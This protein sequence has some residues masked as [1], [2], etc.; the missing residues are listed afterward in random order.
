MPISSEGLG[1]PFGM[2]LY[3]ADA[4]LPAGA[5]SSSLEALY[6]EAAPI[7]V[8]SGVGNPAW[9]CGV[10]RSVIV[11]SQPQL[12]PAHHFPHIG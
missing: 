5:A 9:Q 2:K 8:P 10:S 7:P 4:Q 12:T 3:R 1:T 6:V 11:G